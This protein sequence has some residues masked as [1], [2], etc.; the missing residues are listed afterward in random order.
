[1]INYN[2]GGGTRSTQGDA[3]PPARNTKKEK[4]KL[5]C[6]QVQAHN[7]LPWTESPPGHPHIQPSTGQD[8]PTEATRG[9]ASFT[10]KEAHRQS[11]RGNPRGSSKPQTTRTFYCLLHTCTRARAHARARASVNHPRPER[12]VQRR[13]RRYRILK[14]QT[15]SLPGRG[16]PGRSREKGG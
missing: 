14:I 2:L 16:G 3:P 9:E 8:A 5:R 12:D 1:M 10:S 13:R 6:L 7:Y 11:F 15:A 4:G